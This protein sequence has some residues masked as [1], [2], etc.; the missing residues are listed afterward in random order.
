[1][2]VRGVELNEKM[3]P[4]L[5]A[6]TKALINAATALRCGIGDFKSNANSLI[7]CSCDG[8]PIDHSL[9]ADG[10]T[11]VL[12]ELLRQFITARRMILSTATGDFERAK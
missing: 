8:V 6:D 2:L 12:L 11:K 9:Q 4:C 10:K 3:L 7:Y 5:V 1:M